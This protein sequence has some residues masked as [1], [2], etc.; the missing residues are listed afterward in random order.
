MALSSSAVHSS[1]ETANA[2]PLS[3]SA[4]DNR[5]SWEYLPHA[6]A[7]PPGQDTKSRLILTSQAYTYAPPGNTYLRASIFLA[8]LTSGNTSAH[9]RGPGS[10]RAWSSHQALRPSDWLHIMQYGPVS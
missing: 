1:R 10:K 8:I 7:K 6:Q 4:A 9:V 5:S 2:R 3:S